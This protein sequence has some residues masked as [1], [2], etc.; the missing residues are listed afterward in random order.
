M[1]DHNALTVRPGPH[2]L[3]GGRE[4]LEG[5]RVAR[6]AASGR[7]SASFDRLQLA[8]TRRLGASHEDAN[9]LVV[10]EVEREDRLPPALLDLLRGKGLGDLG[11]MDLEAVEA[12][13]G[14]EQRARAPRRWCGRSAVHW[15]SPREALSPGARAVGRAEL[16]I[17][18]SSRRLESLTLRTRAQ[19]RQV[20]E[21]S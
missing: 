6:A 10:G 20:T 5:E 9:D 16:S 21:S 15:P 11:E 13:R 1:T 8:K 18:L 12:L 17:S 4:L 14:L 7:I 19:P 2:P 3:N